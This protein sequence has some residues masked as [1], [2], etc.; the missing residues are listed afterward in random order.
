M[1]P[2]PAMTV[3]SSTCTSVAHCES[4]TGKL[5]ASLIPRPTF[6][7]GLGTRLTVGLLYQECGCYQH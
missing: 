6:T 3:A 1:L 5:W 2:E 7:E 4:K